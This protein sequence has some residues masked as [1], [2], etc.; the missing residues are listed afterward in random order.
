MSSRRLR[1]VLWSL[2]G[3]CGLAVI[4]VGVTFVQV[5]RATTVDETRPVDAIVVLGAAQYDGR[6]SPVFERR[7]RRSFDLYQQGMAPVIVTTGSNQPGDRF[8][9]GFAG[10]EFLRLLGVPEAAILVVVDG[11]N[12]WEQLTATDA[13]LAERGLNRV[14][15][16]SD[17]YHSYRAE[18]MA[19]SVGLEAYSAPTDGSSSMRQL[20]RE[21]VAVSVGRVIGYRRISNLG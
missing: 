3:L 20:T 12:T 6:P 9:E 7:L 5:W 16:V 8:T 4:Y 14:L 15:L 2:I 13:V 11:S 19:D 10:Y 17:P 21:T 18:Q 1:R